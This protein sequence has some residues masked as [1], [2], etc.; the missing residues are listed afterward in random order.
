MSPITNEAGQTDYPFFWN[1]TTHLNPS[2]VNISVA[3]T[4]IDKVGVEQGIRSYAILAFGSGEYLLSVVF[5]KENPLSGRIE[6]NSL[7]GIATFALYK[8][9]KSGSNYCTGINADSCE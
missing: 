5:N 1:N 8:N 7:S 3:I 9:Q 4:Y 6:I 2:S